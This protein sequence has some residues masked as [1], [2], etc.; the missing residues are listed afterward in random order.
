MIQSDFRGLGFNTFLPATMTDQTYQT[1]WHKRL[2]EI[3]S[4]GWARTFVNIGDFAPTETTRTPE[5]AG[6][7][8]LYKLLDL[9]KSIGTDVYLSNRYDSNPS[10]LPGRPI[11]DPVVKDKFANAVAEFLKNL[12]DRGYTNVKQWSMTNELAGGFQTPWDTPT[13]DN[14][15]DHTQRIVAALA[16]KGVTAIHVVAP[17]T[18]GHASAARAGMDYVV[19]NMDAMTGSYSVHDYPSGDTMYVQ[20]P[21]GSTSWYPIAPGTGTGWVDPQRYNDTITLYN[22][23]NSHYLWDKNK[24]LFIGEFGGPGEGYDFTNGSGRRDGSLHRD[25][26]KYGVFLAE[27][28]LAGLNT[29]IAGMAKWAVADFDVWYGSW[30]YQNYWGSWS[31]PEDGNVVRPADYNAYGLLTRFVRANSTVFKTTSDDSLVHVAGVQNKGD[32]AYTVVA[33]NRRDTTN[34]PFTFTIKNPAAGLTKVRKYVYDPNNVPA[35]NAFGD[36]PAHVSTVSVTNGTFTDTLPAG[37]VVIYTSDFDETA[38]AAV[39]GFARVT[40]GQ[41]VT[42]TWNASSSSDRR[43]YRIYRGTSPDFQPSAANQIV[44]TTAL[45]YADTVAG[46][47]GSYF[48]VVRPVDKFGNEGAAQVTAPAT[49]AAPSGLT[50]AAASTTSVSLAWSDNATDE[51]GYKLDRSTTADFSSGV[52][53]VALAANAVAYTDTGLTPGT[54]YHYRVRATNAAGDSANSNA[55]SATTPVALPAAP[56]GLAATAASS[57]SVSLTWT[58][59]AANESGFKVDYST[60]STFASGVTTVA[61]NTPNATG[62]TVTGLAASTTYYFRVRAT[63]SAG[64]SANSNVATAATPAAAPAYTL[65]AATNVAAARVASNQARVTWTDNSTG[66]AGYKVE[67]STN[68]AT[69]TQVAAVATPNLT[70]YTATGLKKNTVYYFRVRPYAVAANGAVVDGP[71]SASALAAARVATTTS[72]T[73]MTSAEVTSGASTRST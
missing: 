72:T 22:G 6:M 30:V 26:P 60:S 32:G 50:A 61:V 55:A 23:Y 63:N 54:T 69:W 1:V 2:A 51:T 31:R 65:A 13:M 35:T 36:L 16:A 71:Y 25:N 40:S 14:F 42:L 15:K 68:N 43:Y 58:D 29:G 52:T 5:S 17:D 56:S 46:S 12:Q 39:S 47:P 8:N 27:R 9:Y 19:A 41:T 24:P 67:R 37:A 66:E 21:N 10:W 45:T 20:G 7:R 64:D 49:P 38:P 70:S 44:S 11:T 73:S 34:Q 4:E 33:A 3:N 28:V 48:Y 57:S 59:N 62:H 53:A 18:V